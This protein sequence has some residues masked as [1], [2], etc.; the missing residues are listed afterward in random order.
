MLILMLM[1]MVV[2]EL[3]RIGDDGVSGVKILMNW[4]GWLCFP[5]RI[6]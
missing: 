5:V 3:R 6:L 1:R 2:M 4:S